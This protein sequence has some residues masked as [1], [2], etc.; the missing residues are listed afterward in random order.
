MDP[1]NVLKDSG[2]SETMALCVCEGHNMASTLCVIL[3]SVD[4]VLNQICS[5]NK[6]KKEIRECC[7]TRLYYNP[8]RIMRSSRCQRQCDSYSYCR[9][10][11]SVSVMHIAY[12]LCFNLHLI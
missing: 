6:R 12:E 7:N 10:I 3:L 9:P 8:L 2:T 5:V 11:V 4:D 1:D